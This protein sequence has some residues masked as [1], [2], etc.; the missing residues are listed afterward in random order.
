[1]RIFRVLVTG[2]RTWTDREAVHTVL[3]AMARSAAESGFG[4]LVVVHGKAG[5]LD[6]LADEWAVDR[7][8]RGWR[9]APERHPADWKKRGRSRA[10]FIRNA[11]MVRRG[12]DVCFAFINPCTEEKC[13]ESEPHGTHGAT[14]CVELA[15]RAGIDVVPIWP[16]IGGE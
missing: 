8:G 2:S 13:K 15:E 11:Q 4:G 9:V 1:V 6:S 5:G 7:Q 10:G 14:N 12:A 16:N 3:D